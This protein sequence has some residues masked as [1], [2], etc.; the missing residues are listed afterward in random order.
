MSIVTLTSD[1]GWKDY[2]LPMIKG[3]I[4]CK[5]DKINLVDIVHD[6]PNYDI[7]QAAFIFKNCWKSFPPGTIHLISVNDYPEDTS[8][9]FVVIAH[10]KHY[11]IGPDN[12][13]FSLI[14]EEEPFAIYQLEPEPKTSFPLAAIYARAVGHIAAG[15]PIHEIGLPIKRLVQRITFSPVQSH[16]Q[17]RGAVIHVDHYENVILNISREIFDQI[18]QGRD[19]ALYFKRHDPIT[20]LSEQYQD[21]EV[22]EVL[23]LFNAANLLE[24]AINMGKAS[25]MLGLHMEDT[26]QID[27]RTP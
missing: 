10:E 8:S 25:S 27:F 26:V 24:I 7:V 1:F 22:G 19:F 21:V 15:K 14:F 12:G 18:G 23:C 5:S 2:Y 3:A 16:S 11:F 6:I 17:I 13:V 20:Q 4:L 9:G